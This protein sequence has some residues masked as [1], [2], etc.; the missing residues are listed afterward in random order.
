M[1]HLALLLLFFTAL[2]AQDTCSLVADTNCQDSEPDAIFTAT[3]CEWR[4]TEANPRE[5][6]VGDPVQFFDS[7]RPG[8]GWH[9]H[10]GNIFD[11]YYP[12]LTPEGGLTGGDGCI[13]TTVE[14]PGF[15]GSYLISA[16]GKSAQTK[17]LYAEA[18]FVPP[19]GLAVPT[20]LPQSLFS[21]AQTSYYD[22][23]HQ[24]TFWLRADVVPRYAHIPMLFSALSGQPLPM[25]RCGLPEG[26]ISDNDPGPS[27]NAIPGSWSTRL[28]E[29]HQHMTECDILNPSD[30]T[31]N[32]TRFSQLDAAVQASNCSW[33]ASAPD[34]FVFVDSNFW[35]TQKLLHVVC[36][37]AFPDH[38]PIILQ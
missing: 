34:A 5:P 18:H 6:I 8:S 25:L 3:Y 7:I 20:R 33:G 15:A 13:D 17:T 38:G 21:V 4:V 1:R 27:L 26:G 14:L 30:A 2:H 29:G 19:T 11:R 12:L 10:L 32:G 37:A 22:A 9:P 16:T 35:R 24:E 31:D 23:W 28:Y 36:G